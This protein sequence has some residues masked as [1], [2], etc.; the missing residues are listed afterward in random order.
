MLAKKLQLCRFAF[1]YARVGLQKTR[2]LEKFFFRI[3]KVKHYP[4]QAFG[5]NP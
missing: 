3:I 5:E 1:D 2:L 4:K